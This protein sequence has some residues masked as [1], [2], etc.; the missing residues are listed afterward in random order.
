MVLLMVDDEPMII[1]TLARS[2]STESLNIEK[3]LLAYNAEEAKKYFLNEPVIDLV[4]CDIEMPQTN[5]I[6]LLSWIRTNY[7]QTGCVFVTNYG[8]F[9]YAQ[10]AVRLGCLDYILKPITPQQITASIEK[11]INKLK[12]PDKDLYLNQY[13]PKDRL[14]HDMLLS[15]ISSQE[16]TLPSQTLLDIL[17]YPALLIIDRL[18][19][20]N[21]QQVADL[22]YAI[23]KQLYTEIQTI[24]Q[25]AVVFNYQLQNIFALFPCKAQC[26]EELKQQVNRMYAALGKNYPPL[27]CVTGYASKIPVLL[28]ELKDILQLDLHGPQKIYEFAE[29]N[30]K[31]I[32]K[33]NSLVY[34]VQKYIKEH[35]EQEICRNTVAD[36][37][38][39]NPDYLDR[40]FKKEFGLSVSQYIKEKKID[41][42]KTLLRT[43]NLSVSEIA[44][45]LGY[46][47]LSHFIASF[48][49]ITNMT[50]VNYRKKY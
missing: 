6:T 3:I 50:P 36:Y 20:D 19:C 14:W 4:M 15:Y 10:E 25:N 35:L 1:Q 27:L 17:Y 12:H 28:A 11:C 39:M 41:Y 29:I 8:V 48:K 49:Q 5:G 13:L 46:I 33:S 45:R 18:K 16:Y 30:E 9:Q 40:L 32:S 26:I 43:T 2:I 21:I 34:V 37:I 47:N 44:Q 22:R 38:H 23:Q 42:A 7:P 24:D 31:A